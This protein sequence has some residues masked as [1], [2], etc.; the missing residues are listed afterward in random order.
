MTKLRNQF[1]NFTKVGLMSV[2]LASA[3]GIV[4]WLTA[5]GEASNHFTDHPSAPF[6]ITQGQ[7]ARLNVVNTDARD[8]RL[9]DMRFLDEDGN[10][11]KTMRVN[12]PAKHSFGLLLPASEIGRNEQRSQVRA[13]VRMRGSRSNRLLGNVEIYD[14]VTGATSFGLLLPASDFDPQPEPPAPQQ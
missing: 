8:A 12:V 6:G 5:V 4:F 2:F 11:L 13:V 1:T 10:V 7:V 3:V 9:F 14:Q